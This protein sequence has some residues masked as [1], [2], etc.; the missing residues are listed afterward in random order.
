MNAG[1][2]Q[3][4]LQGTGHGYPMHIMLQTLAKNLNDV[5]LNK[6]VKKVWAGFEY[7]KFVVPA[8]VS[9]DDGDK[10]LCDK[11]V[12]AFPQTD[13]NM[14]IFKNL[15]WK[16]ENEIK[17][18][19]NQNYYEILLDNIPADIPTPEPNFLAATPD[20]GDTTEQPCIYLRSFK[21]GKIEAFINGGLEE[22]TKQSVIDKVTAH[23]KKMYNVELN[24]ETDILAF[25]RNIYM[26]HIEKQ[27][28]DFYA[29]FEKR[30]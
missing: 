23:V 8:F 17:H 25:K 30:Q 18:V 24:Q 15:A 22:E 28:R 12:I 14:D 1:T 29:N 13:E 21:G 3:S 9:T 20:F 5:R 27:D 2:F 26:P 19:V 6:R 4:V 10:Y 16:T 7:N 11:V